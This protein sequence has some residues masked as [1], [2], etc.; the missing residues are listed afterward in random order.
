MM[1]QDKKQDLLNQFEIYLKEE[2][3][4]IKPSRTRD[5]MAYSLTAGGKRIRPQ[6]LFSLLESYGLDPE[7]GFPAATAIEMIHTYS[8][9]HDDLPAMDN[10]DFRRGRP[11][12]HK[13][14]DEASAILAGDGLLTQAFLEVMNTQADP[15]TLVAMSRV[16]SRYAGANGMIYGQ[17]LDLKAENQ[18]PSLEELTAIDEYKTGCLI[19]LPLELGALIAGRREDI[20]AL[21]VVGRNIGIQFQMQDDVLDAT[22]TAQELGKTNSDLRNAKMTAVSLL[23]LEEAEKKI[24]GYDRE[25]REQIR[26]LDSLQD[27][28]PLMKVIDGLL[29]RQK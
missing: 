2:T 19:Q 25:I 23:G 18:E 12:C 14:F 5:A 3:E 22:K 6:L 15:E 1:S 29:H 28:E 9:I 7:T 4:K 17:D 20:P 10:D 26:S 8:L 11:S 16:L 27:A 21:R 13:A 24:E